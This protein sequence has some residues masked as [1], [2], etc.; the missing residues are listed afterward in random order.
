MDL[1]WPLGQLAPQAAPK[2]L[3]GKP[4]LTRLKNAPNDLFTFFDKTKFWKPFLFCQ[5]YFEGSYRRWHLKLR[6]LI[7]TAVAVPLGH[8]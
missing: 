2:K 1:N 7:A 6:D 8:N 3:S 4:E 5:N